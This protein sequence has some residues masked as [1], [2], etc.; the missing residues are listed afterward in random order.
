LCN[1]HSIFSIGFFKGLSASYIGCFEGAI[2][3][4]VYEKLKKTLELGKKDKE[5]IT[6]AEYARASSAAKFVAILATYPHEVVRTRLR[7]QG[8]RYSGFTNA[9]KIIAKEEGIKGLYGGLFLHLARSVPNAAIMFVSFELVSNYLQNK[10]D[11]GLPI[12]PSISIPKI[13]IR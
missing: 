3:W 13:S 10:I 1:H 7:Q 4:I 9:L 12:L 5:H 6:P 2:Q 8:S 11:N